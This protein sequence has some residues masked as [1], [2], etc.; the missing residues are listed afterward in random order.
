MSVY[1]QQN[2]ERL[3]NCKNIAFKRDLK[4]ERL[5]HTG[6]VIGVSPTAFRFDANTRAIHTLPLNH[7]KLD[8]KQNIPLTPNLCSHAFTHRKCPVNGN[9]N[10]RL[11]AGGTYVSND[12]RSG[13]SRRRASSKCGKRKASLFDT[14][15]SKK[16]N[17]DIRKTTENKRICVP[18]LRRKHFV[19]ITFTGNCMQM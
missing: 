13:E 12:E 14:N 15:D 9:E 19:P 2:D 8:D 6:H 17:T 4:E 18:G 3:G 16:L 1:D 10:I 5:T 11:H 7:A